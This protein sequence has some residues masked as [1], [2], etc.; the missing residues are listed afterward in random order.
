MIAIEILWGVR[1]GMQTTIGGPLRTAE[2]HSGD[3]TSKDD[4]LLQKEKYAEIIVL[5]VSAGYFRARI[6]ARRPRMPP[7]PVRGTPVS[8]A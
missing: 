8:P 6:S 4:K 7:S 1:D 2:E 3:Q 5:L